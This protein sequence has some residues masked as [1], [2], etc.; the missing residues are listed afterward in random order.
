MK[1]LIAIAAVLLITASQSLFAGDNSFAPSQVKTSF[2]T[3]FGSTINVSWERI[4]NVF[5][6]RFTLDTE[7][8]EVYYSE[9]GEYL[10]TGRYIPA[11]YLPYTLRNDISTRFS[12]CAIINAIEFSS[13]SGDTSYFIRAENETTQYEL[14]AYDNGKTELIKKTIKQ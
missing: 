10:G 8:F 14:R 2:E 9:N 4:R 6:G 1:K 11:S 12:G 13:A 3:R 5:I 7:N